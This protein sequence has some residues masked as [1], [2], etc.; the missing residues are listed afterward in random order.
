MLGANLDVLREHDWGLCERG[1]LK[2][3]GEKGEEGYGVLKSSCLCMLV[4]DQVSA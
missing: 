4:V 3:G 1:G 2:A